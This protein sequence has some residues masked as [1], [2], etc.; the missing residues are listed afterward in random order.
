MSKNHEIYD[1]TIWWDRKLETRGLFRRKICFRPLPSYQNPFNCHMEQNMWCP[2]L[3]RGG[4]RNGGGR[5]KFKKG[6]KKEANLSKNDDFW[7]FSSFPENI[8]FGGHFPKWIFAEGRSTRSPWCLEKIQ[9]PIWR[10][11]DNLM[12]K[13]L[14]KNVKNHEILIFHNSVR[15][16]TGDPGSI[17]TQNMFPLLP[18]TPKRP[19]LPYGPKYFVFAENPVFQFFPY[20]SPIGPL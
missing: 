20:W 3:C 10:S 2:I 11:K 17:S 8:F 15:Q 12:M 18:V 19:E 13:G 5:N 7:R 4:N 9:G 6:I 1:L 14:S 16:K